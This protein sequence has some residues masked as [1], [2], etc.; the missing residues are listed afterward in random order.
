MDG[1]EEKTSNNDFKHAIKLDVSKDVEEY[2][3]IKEGMAMNVLFILI[4][5]FQIE[6]FIF[7]ILSNWIH[8]NSRFIKK[9]IYKCQK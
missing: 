9:Y 2:K 6:L 8:S 7:S 5:I 3:T 1:K 4:F